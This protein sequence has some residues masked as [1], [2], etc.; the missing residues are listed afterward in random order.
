MKQR[1]ENIRAV[2]N[3]LVGI[4]EGNHDLVLSALD[5]DARWIGG[6]GKRSKQAQGKEAIAKLLKKQAKKMGGEVHVLQTTMHADGDTVFAEYVRSP[7]A[8]PEAKGAE[9]ALTVFELAFG[10]IREVREFTLRVE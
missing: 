10:K 8:K 2:E 3:V 7:K 4:Q 9:R 6:N 1:E 5:E